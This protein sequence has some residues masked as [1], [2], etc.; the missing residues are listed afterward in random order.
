MNLLKKTFIKD[1]QSTHKPEV[2]FRYG[3][4][5][6]IIGIVL[7]LI[8]F[9][10]KVIVGIIGNSITVIAD[11]INNLSD[12]GSSVVTVFGFKI[13]GI[14]SPLKSPALQEK[15]DFGSTISKQRSNNC[16]TFNFIVFRK[17]SQC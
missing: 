14:G 7:N 9:A 6:G 4:V 3:V 16:N 8:L 17:R 13:C 11:A 2:R 1:Y 10:G 15:F 12:A 5:A